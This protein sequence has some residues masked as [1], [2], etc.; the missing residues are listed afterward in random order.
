MRDLSPGEAVTWPLYAP[1][2][3]DNL[4]EFNVSLS[5]EFQTW[6]S[7]ITGGA[8]FANGLLPKWGLSPPPMARTPMTARAALW[9]CSLAMKRAGL[10]ENRI[11]AIERSFKIG[12]G[13]PGKA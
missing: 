1:H 7:R 5:V 13:A 12:G 10:A 8:Y 2:R 3:V 6:E 11:K 4:G 9:L